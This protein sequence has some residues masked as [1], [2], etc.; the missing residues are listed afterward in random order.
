MI[1]YIIKSSN[2]TEP[3]TSLCW[4]KSSTHKLSFTKTR[5]GGCELSI[6]LFKIWLNSACEVFESGL[7][8]PGRESNSGGFTPHNNT[9][10]ASPENILHLAINILLNTVI[11]NVKIKVRRG[12]VMMKKILFRKKKKKYNDSINTVKS[13]ERNETRYQLSMILSRRQS[14]T[15]PESRMSIMW[16]EH[17]IRHTPV[18]GFQTKLRHR[19]LFFNHNLK[20]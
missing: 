4:V 1:H 17:V 19:F 13:Y 15:W 14:S 6:L 16:Q 11:E 8:A 18:S 5:S 10:T 9:G 7:T 20:I 2:I 3:L 12:T